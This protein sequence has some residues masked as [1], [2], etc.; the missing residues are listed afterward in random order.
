MAVYGGIELGGTK[1][2][3]AIGD[4][5]DD[6]WTGTVIPTT[7][8]ETT[9][10][11]AIDWFRDVQT[12]SGPLVSLGAASFGPLDPETGVI[13]QATPKTAWRGWPVRAKFEHALGVPVQLDTDVNG[14]ARAER[15]WGAAQGY[16]DVLYITIGTGIGV[17]A[18]VNGTV[19]HGRSHPEMGHMR[20]PQHLTD[21]QPGAPEQ[22]WTGNCVIH[23]NCWEGLA[24]GTAKAQRSAL[25]AQASLE[26]PDAHM[27]ESE[28]IALGLV[29]L[30]CTY[31]PERVVIGGGVMRD[32]ALLPRIR[33]RTRE[34]L[35][36]AYFPEASRMEELVV[37][38]GLGD[39]AGVAGAIL[40]AAELRPGHLQ[41]RSVARLAGHIQ[42]GLTST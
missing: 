1:C 25:W 20:I 18:I 24:S 34:L 5:S 8:P 41:C 10:E 38:P 17:G 30:I 21:R 32:T 22:M 35:D 9:T 3:C 7:D 6:A 40:L 16:S 26:P 37:G 42:A 2:V 11:A 39:A 23:G 12:R 19:V 27:L 28:Y 29:N 33:L 4:G 14:A 15:A 36:A 13:T 31:R